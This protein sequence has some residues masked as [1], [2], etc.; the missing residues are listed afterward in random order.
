MHYAF[1]TLCL[2]GLTLLTLVEPIRKNT[3]N[4]AAA[5]A[6]E[7]QTYHDSH[8]AAEKS[9]KKA[10]SFGSRLTDVVYSYAGQIHLAGSSPND[11]GLVDAKCAADGLSCK[12]QDTCCSRKCELNTCRPA[13]VADALSCAHDGTC[14]SNKC[15]LGTCR[16]ACVAYGLPCAHDGTCC[17]SLCISGQCH[18]NP[19]VKKGGPCSEGLQCCA[20]LTCAADETGTCI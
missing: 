5:L 18:Q 11:L 10:E 20:G 19:C 1:L 4:H 17:S 7:A 16:P 2:L 6:D 15:E 12:H 9:N 8:S 14:C 3:N 13:C